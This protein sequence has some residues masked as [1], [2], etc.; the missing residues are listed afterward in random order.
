MRSACL[1]H[2]RKLESRVHPKV[3]ARFAGGGSE[4]G[5]RDTTGRREAQF[6]AGRRG[7]GPR[8]PPL[9]PRSST[10]SSASAGESVAPNVLFSVIGTGQVLHLVSNKQTVLK[11][12]FDF[13]GLLHLL[14]ESFFCILL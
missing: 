9:L 1:T 12:P 3:H 4:K 11:L 8:W 10:P 2:Q 13:S 7:R 5:S 14:V 6:P